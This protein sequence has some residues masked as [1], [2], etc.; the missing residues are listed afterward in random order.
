MGYSRFIFFVFLLLFS[1]LS[2]QTS[3]WI[4]SFKDTQSGIPNSETIQATKKLNA[5][6]QT[7]IFD[8]EVDRNAVKTL[9]SDETVYFIEPDFPVSALNVPNDSG[10]VYQW[11]LQNTGQMGGVIGA[12]L[13]A[14]SAWGQ[15]TGQEE[16]VVGI[17]D[18]GIDWQH[19]DL[20]DNIWQ[21]L[22]EDADGDGTVLVW[23]GSQWIFDP[24]DENGIDDDGNGYVD[25]FV[26]WDFVNND[27]DPS[28]D[29]VSGHGTHVSGI[30]GA[31]GNNGKGIAGIAWNV[32]LMGL[33]FLNS[34]GL[35]YTSD[36]ILALDYALKMG[37]D[38]SN[39]SW[40]GGASSQAFSQII[41][42]AASQNHMLVA[43]A[44]NNFGNDNDVA[45]LYPAG[46]T[47]ENI[48]AV[49]ASTNRD[50]IAGFSNIGQNSVDIFAPGEGIYSTLPGGE[51][52]YR[53]GTS[54]A[55]PMVS[56]AI[57]LLI[58]HK[59]RLSPVKISR[60]LRNQ[61][62]R[63]ETMTNASAWGGRLDLRGITAPPKYWQKQTML[64][65]KDAFLDDDGAS[66]HIGNHGNN[67]W[68][69]KYNSAG[70]FLWMK[71]FDNLSF[72]HV[73]QV[74]GKIIVSGK[75]MGNQYTA[76]VLAL[77]P[78]GNPLWNREFQSI[79]PNSAEVF[80][81]KKKDIY[82]TG[83]YEF[84]GSKKLWLTKLSA[85]GNVDWVKSYYFFGASWA[86]SDI[87]FIDKDKLAILGKEDAHR[88]FI[89][90][91]DLK[92]AESDFY[93]IN[94]NGGESLEPAR[95]WKT[96]N[97]EMVTIFHGIDSAGFAKVYLYD[98]DVEDME[99]NHAKEIAM[100]QPD[101]P[102]L[103]SAKGNS[104]EI[105]V[106]STTEVAGESALWYGRLD[107][108]N[109]LSQRLYE[110]P[111]SAATPGW[112]QYHPA[113]KLHFSLFGGQKNIK[114]KSNM[115][116]QSACYSSSIQK[117][118]GPSSIPDIS[119]IFTINTNLSWTIS[120]RSIIE[121]PQILQDSLL[122]D[123]LDCEVSANF[124][125]GGDV[126]CVG[127][128]ITPLNEAIGGENFQWSLDGNSVS[129]DFSPTIQL[130]STIGKHEL[131]LIAYDG[132]CVD[133]FSVSFWVE[134]SLHIPNVD[135]THCGNNLLLT[136]PV[137]SA[138]YSFIW[139]DS[140]NKTLST[141]SYVKITQNGHYQLRIMNS[142]G[143]ETVVDYHITLVPGCVWPGDANANGIV[144]LMDYL[145]MGLIHGET[146][147]A[148]SITSLN[149]SP[150]SASPWSN[151]FLANHPIAPGVN[152]YHSDSD[153]N[154]IV[155]ANVD[156]EA[157]RRNF[158]RRISGNNNDSSQLTLNINFDQNM[159]NWL[160]T[161]YFSITLENLD[162]SLISDLYGVALTLAYDLPISQPI[163]IFTDSSW[164]NDGIAFDTL[165]WQSQQKRRLYIGMTRL[166]Q[167]G[168]DGSGLLLRGGISVII[169]DI[170]MVSS[171]SNTSFLN[172]KI[173]NAVLIT[174]DGS[175]LPFAGLSSQSSSS[176]LIN[177]EEG[178]EVVKTSPKGNW[179][180]GPNPTIDLLNVFAPKDRVGE[181]LVEMKLVNALGQIK[182]KFEWK[183]DQD[184]Q[185]SL[186]RLPN[187]TY[188]L[189]IADKV[190]PTILPLLIRRND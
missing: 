146:G 119:Q 13:G 189:M 172:L 139:T 16:V 21:N 64:P 4:V 108:G 140:L 54:M 50:S 75:T 163:K 38:L 90:V 122:C 176:L 61:A 66:Y 65:E 95:V 137:D 45:P 133:S 100:G 32:R 170:G 30:I 130:P 160:D 72:H 83:Y 85:S 8:Q 79:L 31:R 126:F 76:I 164:L 39:H 55:A 22:A 37:A 174:S 71:Q 19:P 29:H 186:P 145:T 27:N 94:K 169:D 25:D 40:G 171:L 181:K 121:T 144:T 34:K 152:Y 12:D 167:H 188:W 18:S 143:N 35:G 23:D 190:S 1:E 142:C 24:D 14:M 182:A 124:Q 99:I 136:A 118:I 173:T 162:Q 147:T 157:V 96:Q 26:G 70:E 180:L 185:F 166:D 7:I 6:T 149:F 44:G 41:D 88:G 62:R 107:Q 150:Q 148:R 156:G 2:A 103:I 69:N 56:G 60:S 92:K 93:Q 161:A 68:I 134:D 67:A 151:S 73:G 113:A 58:S 154:G 179:R 47:Q 158:Q 51:Y 17:L 77:D 97:D 115:D 128:S 105:L 10:L 52:G 89:G 91:I 3:R 33:K 135:T 114:V 104:H 111:D 49:G 102:K 15:G 74:D 155:D 11:Y 59:G 109:I 81:H 187:G 36:A 28:D 9:F 177:P 138:Q 48:I 168:F 141:G 116:G 78:A 80:I 86:P 42:Q 183:A 175:Q 184:N 87:H 46:Y 106:M 120:P 132:Y 63:N 43:A 57:A 131:S 84:W 98:W 110:F 5:K 53:S 127:T 165:V 125:L 112:I 123:E 153:G 178:T 20:V 82:L 117:N 129:V 101:S 159:A